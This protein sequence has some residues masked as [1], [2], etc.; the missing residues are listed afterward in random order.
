MSDLEFDPDC[1][2]TPPSMLLTFPPSSFPL[3]PLFCTAAGEGGSRRNRYFLLF[4][5]FTGCTANVKVDV[6]GWVRTNEVA[7]LICQVAS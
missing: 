2:L 6:F 1:D 3:P 7:A 5:V 4:T